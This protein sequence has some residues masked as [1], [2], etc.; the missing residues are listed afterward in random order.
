MK[1]LLL[2]RHAKSS[3]ELDSKD[4]DR[5][6]NKRGQTDAPVMAKRLVKRNIQPD[7]ILTSPAVR[8]FSTAKLFA[9]EL[10]MKN[11]KIVI[12]P[13]LYLAQPALYTSIIEALDDTLNTV[14]IFSHNPGITDFVNTLTIVQVDDMPT[15][16]IYAVESNMISWKD[17]FNHPVNFLFFDYPKAL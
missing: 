12:I 8:A 16:A 2:I 14:A 5:P 17:F 6:L 9:E 3:W 15:C 13:S 1:T 10:T 11:E 4:I 7:I